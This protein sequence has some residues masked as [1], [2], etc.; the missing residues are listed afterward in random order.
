MPPESL[1]TGEF[2]RAMDRIHER[3][4]RSERRIDYCVSEVASVKAIVNERTPREKKETRK[5]AA[6]WSTAVASGIVLVV[7]ALKLALSK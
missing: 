4:D 1:T 3:F 6:G 7:E 2:N 5:A